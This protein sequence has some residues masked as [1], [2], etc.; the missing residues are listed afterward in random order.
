MSRSCCR[1]AAQRGDPT[2]CIP[3]CP[4]LEPMKACTCSSPQHQWWNRNCV[5]VRLLANAVDQSAGNVCTFL[6]QLTLNLFSRILGPLVMGWNTLKVPFAMSDTFDLY[7]GIFD[8]N[9]DLRRP[10]AMKTFVLLLIMMKRFLCLPCRMMRPRDKTGHS[11]I[12]FCTKTMGVFTNPN[13]GP[14]PF[15]SPHKVPASDDIRAGLR[16][17]GMPRS[18]SECSLDSDDMPY[19]YAPALCCCNVSGPSGPLPMSQRPAPGA[20]LPE[21]EIQQACEKHYQVSRDHTPPVCKKLSPGQVVKLQ[22]KA[23]SDF[24]EVVGQGK[25]K[26]RLLPAGPQGSPKPAISPC[27]KSNQGRAEGGHMPVVLSRSLM[28]PD[29][30]KQEMIRAVGGYNEQHLLSVDEDPPNSNN[31]HG[32]ASTDSKQD[33]EARRYPYV[34]SEDTSCDDWL[35]VISQRI[36][37]RHRQLQDLEYRKDTDYRRNP[38]MESDME[39]SSDDWVEAPVRHT[40]D[41]IREAIDK[42]PFIKLRSFLRRWESG[43]SSEHST[44]IVYQRQPSAEKRRRQPST[45]PPAQGLKK[46]EPKKRVRFIDSIKE[47][48]LTNFIQR[49]DQSKQKDARRKPL[50]PVDPTSAKKVPKQGLPAKEKDEG[51]KRKQRSLKTTES[52]QERIWTVEDEIREK[53]HKRFAFK[54]QF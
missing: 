39:S 12:M 50:K 21:S 32:I 51:Q 54:I 14:N 28:P 52:Q 18:S 13:V 27:E 15:G 4:R 34:P 31:G 53:L 6:Y 16:R 45:G 2:T 19:G 40:R 42:A 41:P 1:A 17:L 9:G 5:I 26:P 43:S 7:Y 24:Y 37:F 48:F 25:Y 38:Y 29:S 44:K 36:R 20:G 35:E 47:S 23:L 11:P 8:E 10:M 22:M 30:T 3:W 46:G 33:L 49:K